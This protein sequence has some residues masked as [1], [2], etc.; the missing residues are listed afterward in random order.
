MAPRPRT[1]LTYLIVF[2]LF[3]LLFKVEALWITLKNERKAQRFHNRAPA[4]NACY[5]KCLLSKGHLLQSCIP[6][7]Q[8]RLHWILYYRKTR[9]SVFCLWIQFYL[10]VK[11]NQKHCGMS[12]E[13]KNLNKKWSL[14]KPANDL[15]L[16]FKYAL[17]GFTKNTQQIMNLVQNVLSLA[18]FM[19]VQGHTWHCTV[20]CMMF[21]INDCIMHH[22]TKTV[23]HWIK[24]GMFNKINILYRNHF[25][26]RKQWSLCWACARFTWYCTSGT[27]LSSNKQHLAGWE[28][29]HG[30]L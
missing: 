28:E 2:V 26:P 22:D 23:V 3:L 10:N 5:I 24:D 17:Y 4:L 14:F 9:K 19:N 1:I 20:L 11:F 30:S 15:V 6:L 18:T 7:S 27:D 16:C 8:I 12:K 25:S 21:Y 13:E 29:P